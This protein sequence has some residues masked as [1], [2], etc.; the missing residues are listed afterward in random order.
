MPSGLRLRVLD[1]LALQFADADA[2][3]AFYLEV[4][5]PLEVR[6]PMRLPARRA[7]SSGSPVRTGTPT[8]GSARWWIPGCDPCTSR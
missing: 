5:A 3:A 6:E 2:A 8:C 1:H 4:F 7:R